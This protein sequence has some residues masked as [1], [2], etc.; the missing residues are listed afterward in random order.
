MNGPFLRKLWEQALKS[1]GESW[2]Q[3]SDLCLDSLHAAVELSDGSRGL[4]LNYDQE[5]HQQ[6]SLS[7]LR[8]LGQRLLER[9]KQDPLLGETLFGLDDSPTLRSVAVALVNAL[10][11]SLQSGGQV[12]L[13]GRLPLQSFAGLAR[14][15]AIVGFGGYLDEALHLPWLE[16]VTCFDLNFSTEERRRQYLPYVQSVVEPRRAH[17]NVH[18]SDGRDQQEKLA[19]AEVVCISGSTLCNDSLQPL[20]EQSLAAEHVLLE[21]HSAG[22]FPEALDRW[23]VHTVVRTSLDLPVAT[24][25]RRYARQLELGMLDLNPGHYVD[26]LFPERQSVTRVAGQAA[27]RGDTFLLLQARDADDPMIEHEV[28]CFS[29][30]LGREVRPWSLLERPLRNRDLQGCA[31]VLVGGS[32][33]YGA[34]ENRE[35]WFLSALESLRTVLRAELPMFASCWGIQALATALGGRVEVRPDWSEFGTIRVELFPGASGDV[36]FGELPEELWV[37]AGH[38]ESVTALPPGALCLAGS[39][40][41]PH[42]A[43]T[44]PGRPVYACQFHPE[45]SHEDLQYRVRRYSLQLGLESDWSDPHSSRRSEIGLLLLRRFVER[46]C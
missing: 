37:Q 3:L 25:M 2:P 38:S 4:A 10:Y 44:L 32:G 14:H 40:R 17:M 30:A 39:E 11:A 42:Q 46:C 27:R 15:I 28:G 21:G 31:A 6:L 19:T 9:S 45:L 41:C 7:L 18:L 22:L 24:L 26:M 8:R 34:A 1:R 36:L 23:K 43:F 12:V 29:R 35:P 16:T 5:G 13:P 20:L 33:M